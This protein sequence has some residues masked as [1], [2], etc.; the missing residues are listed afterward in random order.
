MG[1][2]AC[3]SISILADLWA[4][5]KSNSIYNAGIVE[6]KFDL[7]KAR[8]TEYSEYSWKIFA[9]GSRGILTKLDSTSCF[10]VT[11]TLW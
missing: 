5:V 8:A 7:A 2:A 1:Y 6:K 4:S 9:V 3:E 10:T 11:P